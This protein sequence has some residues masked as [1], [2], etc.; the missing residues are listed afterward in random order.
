MNIKDYKFLDTDLTIIHAKE[1]YI[2]IDNIG[3]TFWLHKDDVE[4]LSEYFKSLIKE[5]IKK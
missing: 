3:S 4:K 1:D 2:Y 5:Q